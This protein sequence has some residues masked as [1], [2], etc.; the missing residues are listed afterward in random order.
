M[1]NFVSRSKFTSGHW[2]VT[3]TDS[4]NGIKVSGPEGWLGVAVAYGDTPEEALANAQLIASAPKL[5][6]K[7]ADVLLALEY[8]GLRRPKQ[9]EASIREVLEAAIAPVPKG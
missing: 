2:E 8:G 6:Y 9:W 5:F 3:S 4:D 7:L 1:A